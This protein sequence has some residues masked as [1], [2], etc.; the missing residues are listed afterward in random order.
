MKVFKH[1]FKEELFTTYDVRGVAFKD[2][3]REDVFYFGLAFGNFL[4]KRR[5]FIKKI[6]NFLI[7]EKPKVV[8]G[9]DITKVSFEIKEVFVEGLITANVNVVEVGEVPAP[10]VYYSVSHFD[11]EAGV[12][13]TS[14]YLES[15]FSGFSGIK[16]ILNE[17][18][19]DGEEIKE[20]SDALQDGIKVPEKKKGVVNEIDILETYITE[21]LSVLKFNQNS[22]LKIGIDC[23]NS[24]SGFVIEKFIKRLPF[25]LLIKNETCCTGIAEEKAESLESFAQENDLDI[26]FVLDGDGDK[27]FAFSKNGRKLI[28]DELGF[29]IARDFLFRNDPKKTKNIVLDIGFSIELE[30]AIVKMGGTVFYSATGKSNISEKMKKVKSEIGIESRGSI[31]IKDGFYGYDDGIFAILKILSIL[32][33]EAKTLEEILLELPYTFKTNE[34]RIKTMHEEEKFKSIKQSLTQNLNPDR[35]IEESGVKLLFQ[36]DSALTIRVC[37]TEDA[38]SFKAEAKTIDSFIK[39]EKIIEDLK[40]KMF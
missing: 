20:F 17:E 38:I 10:I 27:L 1:S 26:V 28:G 16:F 33:F 14:S 32:S 19:L 23:I 39:L 5:S 22:K 6:F 25:K 37:N 29:I 15:N 8:V 7:G 13:I 21:A 11:C 24:A 18:A 35:V 34:I 31:Y 40:A 9:T 12:S 4:N 3:T 36:E 2:L 30:K